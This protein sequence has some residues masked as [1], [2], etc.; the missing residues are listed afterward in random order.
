MNWGRGWV[1]GWV[2]SCLRRNDGGGAGGDR[3]GAGVTGWECGNDGWAEGGVDELGCGRG[4]GG[5]LRRPTPH[6]TSP[7]EAD[8]R[9]TP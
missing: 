8:L 2:G 3:G 6:L 7:L 9:V 1:L 5:C 4:G